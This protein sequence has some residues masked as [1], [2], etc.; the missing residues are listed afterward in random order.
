METGANTSQPG[1]VP[2]REPLYGA[3]VRFMS[4]GKKSS[5]VHTRSA[6]DVP[7]QAKRSGPVGL[8]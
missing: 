2:P 1:L 7:R 5:A 6:F 8:A 3:R 4:E